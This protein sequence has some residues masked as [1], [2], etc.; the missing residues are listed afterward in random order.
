[1][2][3]IT[4][5]KHSSVIVNCA[6]DKICTVHP[7]VK[8]IIKISMESVKQTFIMSSNI[9]ISKY[10]GH[11]L[12]IG[13]EVEAWLHGSCDCTIAVS[14]LGAFQGPSVRQVLSRSI[15]EKRTDASAVTQGA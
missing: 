3:W 5:V 8:N 1:M 2:R 9:I 12:I 15:R 4:N 10:H 13:K 11:N 14:R 7:N 6:K